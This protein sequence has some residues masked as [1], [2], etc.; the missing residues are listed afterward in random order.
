EMHPI[1]GPT[2]TIGAT[3]FAAAPTWVEDLVDNIADCAAH[4]GSTPATDCT[5]HSSSNAFLLRRTAVVPDSVATAA[6]A[7]LVIITVIVVTRADPSVVIAV[8][9][10]S[11]AVI[12]VTGVTLDVIAVVIIAPARIRTGR[13]TTVAVRCL[14]PIR[15]RHLEGGTVVPV[16]RPVAPVHPIV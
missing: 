14:R 2:R 6:V 10:V 11:I 9:V 16:P 7:A 1:R 4:G 12:A 13:A 8:A 15:R 3:A 5:A